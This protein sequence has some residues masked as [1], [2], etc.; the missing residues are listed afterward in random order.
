MVQTLDEQRLASSGDW[1]SSI[2]RDN[3]DMRDQTLP[4]AE[5][6]TADLAISKSTKIVGQDSETIHCRVFSGQNYIPQKRG[7]CVEGR[8]K[9]T[10]D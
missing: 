1:L 6:T 5:R 7:E 2:W 8:F 9:E 3:L 4:I 10:P